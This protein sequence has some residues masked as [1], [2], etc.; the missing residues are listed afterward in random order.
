MVYNAIGLANDELSAGLNITF[1]G[2]QEQAGRWTYE[3]VQQVYIPYSEDWRSQIKNA[4]NL[5]LSGFYELDKEYGKYL[6]QQINNFIEQYQLHYKVALIAFNGCDI[7][8]GDA[9]IPLGDGAAIASSTHLP[10]IGRFY[11]A[12]GVLNRNETSSFAI[13]NNNIVKNKLVLPTENDAIS[14]TVIIAFMGILR[15]R[16]E[17]NLF[18]S[19]TGATRNYI[20]G[21]IWTGQEA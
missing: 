7:L 19:D 6:G 10:V 8:S 12:D 1:A 11:S 3:I 16:Q 15:W 21:A 13:W 2:F 17:Y 5:S 14:N 20:G 18:A 4:S 9:Y